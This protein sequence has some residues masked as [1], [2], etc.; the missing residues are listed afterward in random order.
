M[1]TRQR[2]VDAMS[3]LLWERGYADT[4]PREVRERAAVGQG[5]QYHHF[6]SK[7]ALALAALEQNIADLEAA[8]PEL[9]GAGSPLERIESYL[10]APRDALRGCKVGRM[11]Q[12]PQVREDPV[13]M[14]PVADAFIRA[15]E[16]WAAALGDAIRDGELPEHLDA[17]QLAHTLM[18]V[19]QGGYVLAMAQ[20]D[21][22]PF[23]AARAGA[24]ALLR[25]AAS[26][27][28]STPTIKETPT[29]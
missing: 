19:L 13:L 24:L 28:T 21:A 18:A 22:A 4:S 27:P 17:H 1:E 5:S 23:E 15:H 20:H 2:L 25:A 7:Q 3:D 6:R 11:T 12:D 16:R 9:A 26:A 14:A 8:P 10:M 29:S